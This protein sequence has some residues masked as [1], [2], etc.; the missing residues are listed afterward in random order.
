MVD[1][2]R[3]DLVAD[4]QHAEAGF[5]SAGPAQQ[6]AGH[7]F[8]AADRQLGG[9]VAK[10]A[11]DCRGLDAIADGRGSAV[12]VQIIDLL[13]QQL[14]VFERIAHHAV[15]SVAICGRRGDVIRIA[16]HPVAD[17]FGDNVGT[18]GQGVV[19]RFQKEHSRAFAH[20]EAIAAG[21][22]RAASMRRVVIAGGKRAHRRETGDTERRDRRFGAPA[23]HGFGVAV[24]DEA[25][26][27]AHRVRAR[28]ASGGRSRIRPFGTGAY[29]DVARAEIDDGGGNEERRDSRRTFFQQ[30]LMLALNHLKAPDAAA[31]VDAHVFRFF[32]IHLELGHV[33]GEVRGGDGKV[34]EPRHLLDLFFVDEIARIEILDFARDTAIMPR[35]VKKLNLADAVLSGFDAS[36]SLFRAD[37]QTTDETDTSH[38]NSTRQKSRS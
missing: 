2:G 22:P 8:G 9:V 20:H 12:G 16:G 21:V 26:A 35:G 24:L 10:R 18:A 13:G 19:E 23:D 30:A 27:I 38:Y 34:H 25:E 7:G 14:G 4:G 6:V 29:G 28:G 31:D 37:S 32:G 3:G 17:D 11:L 15:G 33:E 36:P 1:G 5:E